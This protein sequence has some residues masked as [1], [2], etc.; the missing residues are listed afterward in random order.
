M[1]LKNETLIDGVGSSSLMV[2]IPRFDLCDV[3]AGARRTPHP[4]FAVNGRV[5]DGIYISKYQ[6]VVEKGVARS[7]AD[8]DP[9]VCITW[10]EAEAACARK[11]EG[12]HLMT[13]MEW[14]AVALWCLKN[15]YLPYG[16][17]GAGKDHREAEAVARV[18]YR[19]DEKGILRVATGTGPVTWSHNGAADGI[20]DLNGNVWEW[21]GGFRLVRGELQLM[22]QG[23]WLAIDG[24]SGGYLTPDGEGTTAN[25]VKLDFAE[26]HWAYTAEAVQDA[27]AHARFAPFVQ[28]TAKGLC[29]QAVEL[30]WALALLPVP[31]MTLDGVDLYANNG[32]S[33]RMM[34]RGGRWGQGENAG[35]FKTCLDD[36]RGYC[37]EAVGFRAAYYP[38]K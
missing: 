2:Y 1:M 33:E 9:A 31:G 32:A 37:G 3:I 13:A 26:G 28:T 6:N 12:W 4:A 24:K 34:F 22:Q 8:R 25:S 7:V 23:T 5:L 35:V 38:E 20:Y 21:M 18:S 19:D 11:G 15:G 16:N 17:N 10:D 27:Y 36:P 14:G 29:S 30:L